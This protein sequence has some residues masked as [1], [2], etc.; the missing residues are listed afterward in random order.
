[1]ILSPEGKGSDEVLELQFVRTL[2]DEQLAERYL[3]NRCQTRPVTDAHVDQIASLMRENL[4]VDDTGDV[5]RFREDGALADGQHRLEAVRKTGP[6]YFWCCLGLDQDAVDALDQGM[7]RSVGSVWTARGIPNG[8]SLAAAVRWLRRYELIDRKGRLPSTGRIAATVRDADAVLARHQG[9]FSSVDAI[10]RPTTVRTLLSM[11]I[12]L[13]VHYLGSKTSP[14]KA[15]EFIARLD[16][17]EGMYKGSPI[18]SLRQRLISWGSHSHQRRV[19]ETVKCA[20]AV[21]AWRAFEEDRTVR[22]LKW[23]MDEP[24]PIFRWTE[25]QPAE[26][27]SG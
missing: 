6:R 17:G 16:S 25:Q 23:A 24:F 2:V 20:V 5:I 15:T 14:A 22:I 10:G 9:L 18:Y 1:M 11:P 4:W 3:S 8:N 19:Q 12:A 13:F 26:E 27:A 7:K 21:K